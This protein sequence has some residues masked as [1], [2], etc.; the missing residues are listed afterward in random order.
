MKTAYEL[1]RKN[2]GAT[3]YLQSGPQ[4]DDLETA[5]AA[6]GYADPADWR[7]AN[8]DEI[9]RVPTEAA[10]ERS[11]DLSSWVLIPRDVPESDAD[12]VTLATKLA[13][14]FGQI[15]GGHHKA[16]VID[17]MLRLLTGDRYEDVITQ[18]RDGEDGPE[19]YTWDE[20]IAP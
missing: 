11:T 2:D 6:A 5:M 14:E 18:W 13:L 8:T 4:Y 3:T 19:T 9:N 15:D 7:W 10:R 20:G 17:Q 12:R 16:W 1:W